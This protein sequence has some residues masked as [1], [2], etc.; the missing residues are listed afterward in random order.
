MKTAYI[1]VGVAVVVGL[2]IVFGRG[3]SSPTN[4][5]ENA[6]DDDILALAKDGKKIKA[7]KWYRALHGVGLKEAKDAVE[8]MM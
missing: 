7:I 2:V 1:A 4:L 5:P 6:T 3:S 8:E